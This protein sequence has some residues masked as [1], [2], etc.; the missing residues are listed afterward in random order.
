MIIKIDDKKI[1]MF[2]SSRE[3]QY[4][5]IPTEK[6]SIPK[7][8]TAPYSLSISI[9]TKVSPD[10]IPE[11]DKGNITLLIIEYFDKFKDLDKLI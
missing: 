11:K 8:L 1:D 9:I 5:N 4:L 2:F 6:V 7:Y 10:K 3:N